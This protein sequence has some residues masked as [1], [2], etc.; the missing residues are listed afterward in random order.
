MR[1]PIPHQWLLRAH[2][3]EVLPRRA[4]VSPAS[5]V[6]PGVS[7]TPFWP[8][9][10]E[11]P[12]GKD[13]RGIRPP[14]VS[15]ENPGSSPDAVHFPETPSPGAL[16]EG[17]GLLVRTTRP[18]R[19]R[20]VGDPGEKHNRQ[21]EASPERGEG[22]VG[23]PRPTPLSWGGE[24]ATQ[25]RTLGLGHAPSLRPR[26]DIRRLRIRDASHFS[27]RVP[28]SVHPALPAEPAPAPF[29]A[30]GPRATAPLRSPGRQARLRES[31]LWQPASCGGF[32]NIPGRG[33]RALPE[34]APGEAAADV[35][36]AG[37][38]APLGCGGRPG[39]GRPGS[40]KGSEARSRVAGHK[41]RAAGQTDSPPARGTH[42][43][44]ARGPCVL[45]SEAVFQA[46]RPQSR[47]NPRPLF[48]AGAGRLEPGGA[49]RP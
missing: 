20:R 23:K 44:E 16:R 47:F 9:R 42:A 25:A 40:A 8:G 46:P 7:P 24:F 43:L 14:P 17:P 37:R 48:P 33:S 30:P 18:P 31:L 21:E 27:P 19:Q 10:R 6:P 41:G 45:H 11:A 15:Q 5:P 28:A 22:E 35:S 38:W 4:W 13:Q 39:T 3:L 12:Q 34:G 32:M 36:P 29:L 49:P 2:F 26:K 1:G